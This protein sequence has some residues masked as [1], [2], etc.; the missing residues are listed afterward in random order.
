VFNGKKGS[1]VDSE[2][3]N[4]MGSCYEGALNAHLSDGGE[5]TWEGAGTWSPQLSQGVCVDWRDAASYVW[6][7]DLSG[8][9]S[10]WSLG[11]CVELKD[12]SCP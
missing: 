6:V 8:S 2:E 10:P 9:G 4:M 11:N 7:C 5:V 1:Q 12:A 3:K